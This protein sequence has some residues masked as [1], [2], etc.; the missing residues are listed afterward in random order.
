MG[1]FEEAKGK[2]KAAIGDLTDNPDL[3]REGRAQEKK[4]EAER[5]AT[6]ARAE[7]KAHEVKAKEKELEQEA[8]EEAK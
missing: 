3:T 8:A 6:E 1:V 5:E 7:A 2:A 4:G